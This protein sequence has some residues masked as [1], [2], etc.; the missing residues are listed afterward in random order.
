MLKRRVIDEDLIIECIKEARQL[1]LEA[2]DEE[3][4]NNKNY[5]SSNNNNGLNLSINS[6]AN[7][8]ATTNTNNKHSNV[9]ENG[10]PFDFR[11]ITELSLSFRDI[12]KINHLRGFENLVRLR[13]DNNHIQSIENV[14]H[15]VHL[16]W[17]DLSFNNISKIE[18]LE[19]LH[20]LTD[21]C[22][23]N[24]FIAKIENLDNNQNLQ[25]L[26]LANNCI[27]G[28]KH[29]IL[30]LRRFPKLEALNLKGNPIYDER[31]FMQSVFAYCE[32]LK[33]LDY[34]R[35]NES[36]VIQAKDAKQLQLQKIQKKEAVLQ[37]EIKQKQKEAELVKL[38]T[39]ANIIGV[40]SLFDDM[41]RDDSEMIRLQNLPGFEQKLQEFQ[42]KIEKETAK[43]IECVQQVYREKI[44]EDELMTTSV[45]KVASE[46]E[47]AA[48]ALIKQT[49]KDDNDG[50]NDHDAK[51][52][53]I[54]SI[55]D[56]L[57]EC[58]M[59]CVERINHIISVYEDRISELMKKNLN[60]AEVYFAEIQN[61]ENDQHQQMMELVGSLLERIKEEGIDAVIEPL[62]ENE[63]LRN[64]IVDKEAI[65]TSVTLSHDNHLSNIGRLED[66]IRDR[67]EK[68]RKEKM[69]KENNRQY[70]RNRQRVAEIL[71]F[72]EKY[73]K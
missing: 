70:Q 15:L 56:Q 68:E 35:V 30:Y 9:D 71:V 27:E 6:Y 54:Q 34:Q 72:V 40:D 26:S 66:T 50:A 60:H 41:M 64:M 43:Y 11:K 23:V 32:K 47:L 39:A 28:T 3:N 53:S 17:L 5:H 8:E 48:I 38:L 21:L 52:E 65:T 22:L 18:G 25:V 73:S 44:K 46:S 59:Q 14:S 45:N 29:N 49:Q 4:N 58:E 33:F 62:P 63:A 13:L 12:Y 7:D 55:S 57:M 69:E 31:D 42:A 61:L 19:Q 51:Q 20:K 2:K 67:E 37:Q 10:E 24:N 16:E 1:E 36:D